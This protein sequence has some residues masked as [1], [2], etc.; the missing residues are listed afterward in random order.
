V[1]E[2]ATLRI[3]GDVD[4]FD[5]IRIA[6]SRQPIQRESARLRAWRNHYVGGDSL[7][8]FQ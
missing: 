7:L 8:E 6:S 1:L 2:Q 5:R 3:H 4:V